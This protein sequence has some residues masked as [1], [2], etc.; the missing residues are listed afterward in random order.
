MSLRSS[1]SWKC[2]VTTAFASA[3]FL[4]LGEGVVPDVA[5]GGDADVRDLGERLASGAGSGRRC[6]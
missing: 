3:S 4:R 6:R 5:D 1:S 2:L